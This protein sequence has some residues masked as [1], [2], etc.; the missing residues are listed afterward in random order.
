MVNVKIP[1]T[2]LTYLDITKKKMKGIQVLKH[3]QTT[4]D[5]CTV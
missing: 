5:T 1:D 2:G 4:R 3:I